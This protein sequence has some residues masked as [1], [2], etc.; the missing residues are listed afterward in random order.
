MIADRSTRS[1]PRQ[2]YRGATRRD[3]VAMNGVERPVNV[4]LAQRFVC[5]LAR[6]RDNQRLGRRFLTLSDMA[7]CFTRGL[8]R[9]NGHGEFHDQGGYAMPV[10]F[11]S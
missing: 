7:S 11:L 10:N 5:P 1:A 3:Y 6:L 8:G 4:K 2:L 9:G